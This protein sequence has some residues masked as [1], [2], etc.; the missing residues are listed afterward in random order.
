MILDVLLYVAEHFGEL[1]H[2]TLLRHESLYTLPVGE[3]R[4]Y[5]SF[6]GLARRVSEAHVS[7]NIAVRHT[8]IAN[9][10]KTLHL[11]LH[12]GHN[13]T[14]IHYNITFQKEDD[15]EFTMSF[16]VAVDT[17]EVPQANVS[18]ATSKD[19][20]KK[21][22][23]TPTPEPP[24]LFSD[25]PEDKRAPKI[26]EKMP[27]ELQV[28]IEVPS[29][30][31]SLLPAAVQ[32]ELQKLEEKLLIGDITVKGYNLTK[33]ELLKPY[34][35]L[36]QNQQAGHSQ[37]THQDAAEIPGKSF[38]GLLEESQ[39]GDER[40]RSLN[41]RNPNSKEEMSR[42][43]MAAQDKAATHLI[44]LH[45][46]DTHEKDF[47]AAIARP[48]TPKLLNSISQNKKLPK[49]AEAA[50]G[51]VG[52]RLHHFI[53]ADRGFLPWERKKYFQDLLEVSKA[54]CFSRQTFRFL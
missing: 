51:P 33:A 15:T 1:Y 40:A 22:K 27:D 41:H 49:R 42:S 16:S 9:K 36:A 28:V 29:L 32:S 5:F 38:E 37:P 44:P 3:I 48:M 46:N 35:A 7:D 52:R 24:F 43:D 12:P 18:Q 34:M 39:R 21:S 47:N 45:I 8:S 31:M 4:P 54:C 17:R 2:M 26:Q 20:D 53:V 6:D 10:W 25:I 50:A 23:P 14:Q 11:L 30:N 19:D 13:A